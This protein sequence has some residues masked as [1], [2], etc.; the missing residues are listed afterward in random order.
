MREVCDL[1][2]AIQVEMVERMALAQMALAPHVEDSS[3]IATP[4]VAIREFQQWLTSRPPELD[5]PA[6]EAELLDLIGVR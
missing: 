3:Q 2:Y 1:S 4:D 6:E 5:R